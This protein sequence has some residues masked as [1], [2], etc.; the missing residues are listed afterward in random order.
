MAFV[1]CQ[2]QEEY[3]EQSKGLYA[4]FVDLTKAFHSVS[5]T[6]PWLI[7]KRHVCPPIFSQMV[8]HLHETRCGQI[9][10]NGDRSGPFPLTNGVKQGCILA[11]TLFSIFVSMILRQ[12]SDDLDDEYVVYV[13]YHMDGSFFN[14]RRHQANTMTRK[15]LIRDFLIA[16]DAAPVAHIEQAHLMKESTRKLT[17]DSQRQIF[18]LVDYTNMF[19]ATKA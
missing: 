11:P 4:T 5:S 14:L 13:S 19:G 2:L 8:I 15:R 3:Q 1:F 10:L 7:L 9:R 18:L 17:T 16:Y 6:G 12:V